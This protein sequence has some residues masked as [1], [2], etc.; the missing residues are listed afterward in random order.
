[1]S[2]STVVGTAENAEVREEPHLRLLCKL[3]YLTHNR[4]RPD[5]E[6]EVLQSGSMP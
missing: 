6:R 2:R 4:S 1:M 5:H 3:V